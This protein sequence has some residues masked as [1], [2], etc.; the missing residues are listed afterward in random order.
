MNSMLNSMPFFKG[1]SSLTSRK[2]SLLKHKI[3]QLD[4]LRQIATKQIQWAWSTVHVGGYTI[5][6]TWSRRRLNCAGQL[7][8]GEKCHR[9]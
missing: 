8:L 3:D 6:S 2:K 5:S 1:I 7:L 4:H 9:R